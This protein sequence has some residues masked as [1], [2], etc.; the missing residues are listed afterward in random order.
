MRLLLL[1]CAAPLAA[2]SLWTDLLVFDCAGGLHILPNSPLESDVNLS[3]WAAVL[4]RLGAGIASRAKC[5]CP[6]IS[7]EEIEQR[8]V[9]SV[10]SYLR[11]VAGTNKVRS[12]ALLCAVC[13]PGQMGRGEEYMSF[14]PLVEIH[15]II[16]RALSACVRMT[17]CE[18]L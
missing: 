16:R 8:F 17:V 5:A 7:D 18:D 10:P 15:V 3:S 1:L 13:V 11:H 2:A 14:Y 9:P 4:N 12:R 6:D